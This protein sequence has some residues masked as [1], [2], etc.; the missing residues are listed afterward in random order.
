YNYAWLDLRAEPWVLTVPP[1][2]P[3][4]RYY[5]SQW[6]DMNGQVIGNVSALDD[7]HDGGDYLIA[8]PG[9]DGELPTGVRRVLRSETTI[10]VSLTRV[11]SMGAGDLPGVRAIQEG[12]ALAP[13]SS[14]LGTAAPTPASTVEYPPYVEGTYQTGEDDF[15]DLMAFLL[16]FSHP[17]AMDAPVLEHLRQIGISPGTRWSTGFG[18]DP[19][20]RTEALAGLRDAREEIALIQT[21]KI[22][23]GPRAQFPLYGT[24][25][26]L[27]T[28][29]RHR[30]FG[31]WTGIF[32]NTP[33]QAAYRGWRADQH[34][35]LADGSAHNYTVTLSAEDQAEVRFFWSVTIYELPTPFLYEN[36]QHRHAISARKPDLI[37]D[38]DGSVTLY[39]Q[40]EAPPAEFEP[41]WLPV[42]AG[43]FIAALRLYGPSVAIQNGTWAQPPLLVSAMSS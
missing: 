36:P 3:E 30:A 40:H 17:D 15:F 39:L 33:E 43:H 34:G 23:L 37:R 5:T 19:G 42:P 31:A 27:T 38:A 22:D 14:W 32:G 7:G 12:F 13:L 26:Q 9:W 28:R 21:E 25:E 1:I 6:N 10:A 20:Q 29:Y 16:Q 8:G 18:S 2:A 4:V 24:R 35:D 11:E 41:N